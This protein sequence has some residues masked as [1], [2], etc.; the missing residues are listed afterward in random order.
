MKSRNLLI[1]SNLNHAR[2]AWG[3]LARPSREALSELTRKYR[4]SVALGDIQYIDQRWYVTHAGLLR[5]AER[6]RCSGIR[7]QQVREF[8]DPSIGRWVFKATV[9]KS[10][11]SQGFVGYGDADPLNTS[12]LVRGAEM[13]VAETRAVNRALRKAYG[14]GLC[15]VE[16]L[17]RPLADDPSRRE[18][19]QQV[20]S[21]KQNGSG[22][23]QPRLRDR[24]CLLIRQ[25][26]LDPTLVKLYAADFCGTQTLREASRDLVESFINKLAEWAAKDR[27]GL[28]CHLNSYA[29][30]KEAS[31]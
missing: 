2:M 30:P 4:V 14:I 17:G 20:A 12:P 23:G 22:N 16:E 31:S 13:R 3:H 11:R 19:R 21:I 1:R 6:T 9:Y 26:Q 18:P 24:L 25:H 7:V 8:C 28:L 27:D 15:S 29:Q 5:L 10:P